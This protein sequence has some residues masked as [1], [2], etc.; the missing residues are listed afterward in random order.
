GVTVCI[1]DFGVGAASFTYLQRLSVDAVKIDGGFVR[2]LAGDPR[3]RTMI[4]SMVELCQSMGLETI[5]EMVETEDAA[6][7]LQSLGVGYG[8]GWLFGRPEAEPRTT[9]AALP[10]RR[11]G[12]VEAWG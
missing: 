9:I 11:K 5:A 8:Q 12:A 2:D 10:V 7:A 6:A 3:A 4:R 1:D